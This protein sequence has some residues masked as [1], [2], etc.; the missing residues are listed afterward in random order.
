MADGELMAED[1][2]KPATDG[3]AG[4]HAPEPMAHHSAWEPQRMA[5]PRDLAHVALDERDGVTVATVSGEIDM[6]SVDHVAAALTDLSN[7]A[8]GL[9]VDLRGADYLDSSGIS[10][11][12]DLALR[13]RQ[14][15]QML[16]IV[17]S[18]SSAPRRMLELTAL[19]SQAVVM[20]DLEPAIDAVRAAY[21]DGPEVDGVV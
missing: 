19:D 10:L 14:R 12:H 5:H 15:T 4:G 21:A 8:M 13:L 20:D 16:I 6:S 17:C 7:L 11:L 1:D 3:G 2:R 9:V 18:P